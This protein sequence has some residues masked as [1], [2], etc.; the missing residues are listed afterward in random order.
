MGKG[1]VLVISRRWKDP[2]ERFKAWHRG[3]LSQ[4]FALGELQ[5]VQV[6]PNL[7]VANLVGQHGLTSKKLREPP[8][9]YEAV[10]AGLAKVREHALRRGASVHM[11]RIGCG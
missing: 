6:E 3:E 10:R 2:E 1:L 4:R 8:I 11:P 5:I 9:R 7:W